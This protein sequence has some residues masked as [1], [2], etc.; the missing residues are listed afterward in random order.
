MSDAGATHRHICVAD[1][2][3]LSH[4]T[5][6]WADACSVYITRKQTHK[7]Q[8]TWWKGEDEDIQD[9]IHR[10]EGCSFFFCWV[11]K[12]WMN[13]QFALQELN[14]KLSETIA[15]LLLCEGFLLL[16]FQ[17]GLWRSKNREH[18]LLFNKTMKF[19]F[20]LFL[21]T[22]KLVQCEQGLHLIKLHFAILL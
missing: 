9:L 11:I 12:F 16:F 8:F 14:S 21:L 7:L 1:K 6:L 15:F 20:L 2:N 3:T 13:L 10:E 17:N 22:V 18:S 5:H 4:C 19:T